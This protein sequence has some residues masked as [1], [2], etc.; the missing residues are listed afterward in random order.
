VK[1]ANDEGEKDR[2]LQP[3]GV[4]NVVSGWIV[5]DTGSFS[6]STIETSPG[7]FAAAGADVP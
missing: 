2:K 1:S 4:A 6:T 5:A 3:R 7:S